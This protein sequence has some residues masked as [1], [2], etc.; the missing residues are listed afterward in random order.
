MECGR[1]AQT[2][3][4]RTLDFGEAVQ[5]IPEHGPMPAFQASIGHLHVKIVDRIVMP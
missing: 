4:D 3:T 5:P 2:I 1:S